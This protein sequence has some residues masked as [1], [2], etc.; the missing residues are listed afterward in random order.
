MN[1]ILV[2]S[3]F[4]D[5]RAPEIRVL[6]EAAKRGPFTAVMYSDAAV[7]SLTGKPPKFPEAERRYFLESIRY[8]SRIVIQPT[9][10]FDRAVVGL[11]AGQAATLL[12]RERNDSAKL[13]SWCTA[14]GLQLQILSESALGY[15][16]PTPR[17]PLNPKSSRKKALVTGSF[18][19]FH[20]GHV[21]FFEEA[22]ELGDLYVIV[23]HDA[24]IK[25]LKGPGHPTFSS[26]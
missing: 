7:K 25:L 24:N 23:G 21:R 18:D 9:A 8:T 6:E 20:S 22:S 19:W 1:G 4:D 26:T 14:N 17:C 5:M 15:L 2:I 16:P 11:K 13:R 3:S 10:N 12:D